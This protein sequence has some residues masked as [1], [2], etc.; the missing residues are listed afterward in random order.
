MQGFINPPFRQLLHIDTETKRDMDDM[1]HI[2]LPETTL[3]SEQR[4]HDKD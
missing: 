1:T 3:P 2:K 4:G